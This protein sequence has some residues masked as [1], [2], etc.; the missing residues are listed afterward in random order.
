MRARKSE[1]EFS[2]SCSFEIEMS[3]KK[4]RKIT[5]Q[6]LRPVLVSVVAI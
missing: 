6:D 1:R 3:K 5:V 4:A 2:F